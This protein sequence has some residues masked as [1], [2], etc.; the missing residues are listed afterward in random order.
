VIKHR[1]TA[2][3]TGTR[4]GTCSTHGLVEAERRLPKLTFL[5]IVTGSTR[6][7]V[8]RKPFRCPECGSPVT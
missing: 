3:V 4:T 2:N 8:K 1:Q 5:F 7:L 6:S